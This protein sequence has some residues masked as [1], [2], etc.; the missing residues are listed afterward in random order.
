M[1]EL[2]PELAELPAQGVFDGELVSFDGDGRP[3]F[4]AVCHRILN[5]DY[6]FKLT[7]VVFDLLAVDG[8]LTMALPYAERRRLLDTL[9]LC[10]ERWH[11]SPAFD[12]GAMARR[13]RRSGQDRTATRV[14]LCTR[15]DA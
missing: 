2:V 9:D 10:D 6:S 4:P 1:T 15:E 8:Q 14:R 12:D 5:G 11:V 7:F 13:S 3:D